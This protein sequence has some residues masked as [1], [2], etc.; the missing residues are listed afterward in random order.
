MHPFIRNLLID[1]YFS[2]LWKTVPRSSWLVSMVYLVNFIDV[3][4]YVNVTLLMLAI[5]HKLWVDTYVTDRFISM[6]IL[7]S[8]IVMRLLDIHTIMLI[9]FIAIVHD[10][11]MYSGDGIKYLKKGGDVHDFAY[12]HWQQAA[13][14]Y[15]NDIYDI[16][17]CDDDDD[18]DDDDDYN[19][20]SDND[21]YTD[22]AYRKSINMNKVPL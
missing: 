17:G 15:D 12:T 3:N 7:F 22:S 16:N 10:T 11:I 1:V 9:L 20:Y 8:T 21:N 5:V 18:D 6:T 4:V 13:A 19:E 14:M 2:P